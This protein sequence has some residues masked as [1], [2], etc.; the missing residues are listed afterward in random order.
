MMRT[1]GL[2]VAMAALAGAAQAQV[3]VGAHVGTPGVGVEA[4]LSLGPVFT[5]RGSIDR[6]GHDFDESYDGIDYGGEFD[7]N[8][9]GAFIDLHPFANGF[10][11]SGGAYLGERK[12]R[13][14]AEP[15]VPVEIGG[16][17]FT[18]SQVGQ[19]S[20]AVTLSDLSPFIGVGFDNT[21]TRPGRW[22]VRAILGAALSEDPD[23]ALDSTGGSLSNN[24]AFRARLEDEADRIRDE[25]DYGLFPV[26]QI[27]L[28][29]RF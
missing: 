25:T 4:Q 29:Y 9:V 23:V 7:F 19:L 20:G 21:F 11:I 27:G 3:A 2:A 22:G 26:A 17:V 18:P 1:V 5:L 13:L 8:T 16:A 12:I 15:T 24:A 6:L 28:T 14:D 10:L